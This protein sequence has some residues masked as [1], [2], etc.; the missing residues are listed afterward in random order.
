MI[1]KTSKIFLNEDLSTTITSDLA[2]LKYVT[3]AKNFTFYLAGD[4]KADVSIGTTVT[5]NIDGTKFKGTVTSV[6]RLSTGV[7]SLTVHVEYELKVTK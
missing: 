6:S 1:K 4:S 2:I 3:S 5:V 7:K